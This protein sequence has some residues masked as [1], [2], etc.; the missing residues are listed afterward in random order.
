MQKFLQETGKPG[1]FIIWE[2]AG[3]PRRISPRKEAGPRR[4]P[5]LTAAIVRTDPHNP[6]F[7]P[8]GGSIIG[9]GGLEGGI[10]TR[11][12]L[13]SSDTSF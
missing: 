9:Y 1:N 4:G 7:C 3:R 8:P 5:T 11:R 6:G 10:R 2:A 12:P 13:G